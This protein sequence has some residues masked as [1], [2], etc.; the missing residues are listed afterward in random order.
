MTVSRRPPRQAVDSTAGRR[1]GPFGTAA[2]L[3]LVSLTLASCR[4][5]S[6][7]TATWRRN[8]SGDSSIGLPASLAVGVDGTIY[9]ADPRTRR[10]HRWNGLGD[11]LP[12]LGVAARTGDRLFLAP[13]IVTTLGDTLFIWDRLQQRISLLRT[14]GNLIGSVVLP[15]WGPRDGFVRWFRRAGPAWKVLMDRADSGSGL[16]NRRAWLAEV[17]EGRTRLPASLRAVGAVGE[18]V[19]FSDSSFTFSFRS[20]RDQRGFVL[21]TKRFGVVLVYS[22]DDSLRPLLKGT[23]V[24]RVRLGLRHSNV[25]RTNLGAYRDSAKTALLALLQDTQQLRR[26]DPSLLRRYRQFLDTVG[27]D[28]PEP[29][30]RYAATDPN[31]RLWLML[32]GRDVGRSDWLIFDMVRA[33]RPTRRASRRQ[34]E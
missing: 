21:D 32:P 29:L 28:G 16:V 10:I 33:A 1:H 18:T 34:H 22:A 14:D 27:L 30:F 5:G 6:S 26:Q 31:D 11:R 24:P 25:Q 3:V 12:S 20:P 17:Q 8:L 4:H 13:S 7:Q 15:V 23:L 9:V 19:Q 2:A